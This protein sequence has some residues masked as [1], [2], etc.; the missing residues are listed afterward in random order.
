MENNFARHDLN[1]EQKNPYSFQDQ[2]I[3]D[4]EN[5]IQSQSE[6]D[7]NSKYINQDIYGDNPYYSQNVA[8]NQNFDNGRNSFNKLR[9][10]TSYNPNDFHLQ[11][12]LGRKKGIQSLIMGI[13]GILSWIFGIGSIFAKIELGIIVSWIFGIGFILAIIG[14]GMSSQSKDLSGG[15]RNGYATAGLICSLICIVL[16]LLAFISIMVLWFLAVKG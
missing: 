14:L 12:D 11:D 9:Y 2:K 5:G 10:E 16:P 7:M 3:S 13:L 8:R 6:Q 15:K 4:P 1:L